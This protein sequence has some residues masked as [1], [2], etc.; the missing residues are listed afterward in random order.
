M[1]YLRKFNSVS[2]MNTAIASSEIGIIGLAYNGST[3]VIKKKDAPSGPDYSEP[4]YIDVRGAVDLAATSGLQMSTDKTTWTDT[5]AT[6]LSSGKTYFRVATDQSSPLL[7]NWT[8]GDS[9]DYDIGGNINSLVKT[10]FENDTNCYIFIGYFSGKSKLKSAGN[11]ILPATTL[12]DE[13]YMS[14]FQSCESLT[15]APELP[16]T[17]LADY[18]YQEMFRYCISLTTAPALPATTLAEDC[19]KNMFRD[20]TLLTTAPALPA[21]TLVH[22]CYRFMFY[23]CTSL[24]TA[25]AL[26]ATTLDTLCYSAMF[27]GCTS[28]ATAP[29]LP[30]TTLAENCYDSMFNGCTLLTTAPELSATTLADWCY[31]GMFYGC[32]NLNYIKCLATDIS[33]SSCTSNWVN[34]VAATGT[35]VKNSSMSSW[36]EGANGIPSG[37]TVEDAT[38]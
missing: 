4:F 36:T 16:A 29:A 26:P 10:N 11:L 2:E 1:K 27:A 13:C 37:W 38:A 28:L 30:A 9:S 20:C 15:T 22:G 19:Y 33:A 21:T 5:T 3:P 35:F 14:M 25:P 31:Q 34:G 7:A 18:C 32:T 12:T 8:E 23:S 6:T 24:P 17:T